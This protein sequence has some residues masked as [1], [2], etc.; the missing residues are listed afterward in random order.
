MDILESHRELKQ[1]LSEPYY[2][3]SLKYHSQVGLFVQQGVG[4]KEGFKRSLEENNLGEIREVDF[5]ASGSGEVIQKV[6]G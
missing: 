1:R 3:D 2:S 5:G 4:V 6:N